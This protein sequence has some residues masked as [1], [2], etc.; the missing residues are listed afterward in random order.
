[1]NSFSMI[2]LLKDPQNLQNLALSSPQNLGHTPFLRRRNQERQ[3][4]NLISFH[5]LMG[6]HGWCL[7]SDDEGSI[8]SSH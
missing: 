4:E 6:A 3:G 1:M 2:F 8:V 5:I 7:A